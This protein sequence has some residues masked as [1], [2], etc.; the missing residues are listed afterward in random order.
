[1]PDNHSKAGF[2]IATKLNLVIFIVFVISIIIPSIIAYHSSKD[3]VLDMAKQQLIADNNAY[4]DS[5]NTMMLTGTMGERDVLREKKLNAERIVDVRIIRSDAVSNQFGEGF[6]HEKAQDDIDER[7]LKGEEVIEVSTIGKERI[8]TVAIP[9]KATHNTRGV[10]CLACHEVPV[11]TVNGVIRISSNLA[12]FDKA[13]EDDFLESLIV[14]IAILVIG[15]VLLKI[16]MGR[17][18]V[19]PLKDARD[20]AIRISDGD[21]STQPRDPS[22]DEMGQLH[23]ALN[24]MRNSLSTSTQEREQMQ[25]EREREEAEQQETLR[26]IE[27]GLAHDFENSV[28]N[29]LSLLT[30][31]VSHVQQ[32]ACEMARVSESL[33]QQAHTAASGADQGVENVNRTATA[34]EQLST[35]IAQVNEQISEVLKISEQ[36]VDQADVTNV[37]V[38]KLA[39]VSHGIG[40]VVATIT[41]IAKQTN[42]LALNASIEAA[43]AGE[44]GRGFAVVASEVKDL[45]QQTAQATEEIGKQIQ[46]MQQESD[47]ASKTIANISETIRKMNDYSQRVAA[48][49]GEQALATH[50]I[51][52]SAQ[53]VSHGIQSIST[54][55]ADVSSAS[56]EVGKTSAVSLSTA[57]GMIKKTSEVNQRVTE[58]LARLRQKKN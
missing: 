39:S 14:N 12:V 27:L 5:L 18:I 58:F 41:D 2:S 29:L 55:V 31:E 23:K 57:S 28:G 56:E 51:S 17:L 9:Y 20:T 36:A 30:S 3:R 7:G 16:L 24:H 52:E 47:D 13:V 25:A 6:E 48:A 33:T 42:M 49:M 53:E 54:A 32:S 22:N 46:N 21:F 37:T 11:G 40:S 26:K 19:S 4:F 15:L 1:M 44:A 43:R 35:S 38:E 50:E 8:L 45:A 34:T 10:D